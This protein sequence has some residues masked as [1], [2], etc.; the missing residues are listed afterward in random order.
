L[1]SL[2]ANVG[3]YE[4]GTNTGV[5]CSGDRLAQ[6]RLTYIEAVLTCPRSH[7]VVVAVEGVALPAG[8]RVI[9]TAEVG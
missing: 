5:Q 4:F 7:E 1:R 2:R 3:G 9:A 6:D 8:V